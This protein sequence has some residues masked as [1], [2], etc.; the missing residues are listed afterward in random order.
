M[1][2]QILEAPLEPIVDDPD[3]WIW[4]RRKVLPGGRVRFRGGIYASTELV[5]YLGYT[6]LI[7]FNFIK[8]KPVLVE[9]LGERENLI[10][11]E[12]VDERLI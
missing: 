2:T 11:A 3:E 9:V 6:V 7:Y 5:P 10:T 4:E 8:P 12:R 1:T